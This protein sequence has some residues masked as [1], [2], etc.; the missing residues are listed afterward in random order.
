M[1]AH[2]PG[3]GIFEE[4]C[5]R[6]TNVYFDASGSERV[7]ERDILE[8]INLFGYEHVVFGS[9]TPYARVE[10]QIRKI[11][12]LKISDGGKEPIFRSNIENVLLLKE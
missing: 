11:E 4:K 9:D 12:R 1:I 8:T 6:L 3:L 7:R 5:I 2:M 10:D